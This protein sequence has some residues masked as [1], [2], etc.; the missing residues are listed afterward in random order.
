MKNHWIE[1][2]R[3]KRSKFWTA[4]FSRNGKFLL[5]PRKV[6]ISVSQKVCKVLFLD[7]MQSLHDH[8]LMDFITESHQGG[9]TDM[10][11]RLR[12][13]RGL[14]DS[15]EIENYELTGLSY[16]QIGMGQSPDDIKFEFSFKNHKHIVLDK[17]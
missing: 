4:E 10:Y 13:F 9:M 15:K 12:L 6:G 2:Y 1:Q 5:K 14:V 17:S 8:E 3:K 11:S 16:S 7:S